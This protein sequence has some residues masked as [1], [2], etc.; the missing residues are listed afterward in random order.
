[1]APIALACLLA[2]SASASSL[3]A[4]SFAIRAKRV[5]PCG[6]RGAQAIENGVVVVRDGR[7]VAVGADVPIPSDL[8]LI[9]LPDGV[10]C[11]GFVDAGTDLVG[12]H[13]GDESVSGVYRAIDGFDRY[14]DYRT[15]LETGVTT[16][17]IDPGSHRLISGRA[18]VVR[19]GGDPAS[20]VLVADGAIT[21]NLGVFGAQPI[22]H[23]PFYASSDEMI[24]PGRAQRPSSRLSALAEAQDQIRR[25]AMGMP[26]KRYDIHE[27]AFAE[28]WRSQ[29]PVRVQAREAVDIEGAMRLLS[30]QQRACCVVGLT[31]A[32]DVANEL[33]A[34]G[35]PIVLSLESSYRW[36]ARDLGPS[37]DAM[38]DGAESAGAV[39]RARAGDSPIALTGRGQ[40]PIA[41]LRMIA[42]LA[43]RGGMP[44]D[45]ALRA[46]TSAPA[47]ILG[48]E[49]RVGAIAPGRDA[50]ILVLSGDPLDINS[51]VLR[52]YIAGK[53]AYEAPRGSGALV[54]RAGHVWTGESMMTDAQVLV[55]NGKI[56]AVGARVPHPR[57]ARIIDAG[58]DAFVTPGFIDGHGHLGFEGDRGAAGPD[59]SPHLL[60]AVAN[61]EFHRVARAGVTTVMQTSYG[62][63]Q[64]GSRISAIKTWGVGYERMVAQEL[65]GMY[66]SMTGQEP[67]QGAS[68]IKQAL[69]AGKKY[70]EEWKKYYD[71]LKKWKEAKAAGKKVEV[72]DEKPKEEKEEKV[73]PIT[74]LWD[75]SV[76]GD[77]LPE[78]VEG[79]MTLELDGT[80]ITGKLSDPMGEAE[81]ELSGT[82]NGTSVR[83][84]VEADTD[85]G[86]PVIN[87]ELDVED[88]MKG[89]AGLGDM[90][91][92]QFEATRVERGKVQITMKRSRSRGKDGKPVPPKINEALEPIRMLLKGEIPALVAAD[93]PAEISA[94]LELL[95]DE[96]KIPVVLLDATEATAVVEDLK[97]RA[98]NVGVVAPTRVER[99]R[100]ERPYAEAVDLAGQGVRVALQSNAEDGAR[101]LPNMALFAVSL[102]MGGDAALRALTIDAARMYRVDDHV[103]RLAPGCDG[104]V[105]I[106]SGHPFDAD[107]RLERVIVGGEEVPE[108]YEEIFE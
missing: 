66:F 75:Y 61:R 9:D 108:H 54:V 96:Y 34:S 77:P 69:E 81:V 67:S 99:M 97:K 3:A 17:S 64:A 59:V 13:Y 60:A 98:E 29:A 94:A 26:Q 107:S 68:R 32:D 102:G 6:D 71:E 76:T 30:G 100:D 18:A 95:V 50:D 38:T 73:D 46:I 56:A 42:A 41:D 25:A 93:T 49:D 33:I 39:G 27:L 65:A 36:P 53:V 101:S 84:E 48:V 86:K 45:L 57:D 43:M 104:D 89:T 92:F 105:L 103:G 90:F 88:H 4:D 16:A 24:Q 12:P 79:P 72:K 74:G 87:A 20:R 85:L 22:V 35:L 91:T 55:E 83:L 28:A 58:P 52:T 23:V 8:L 21:I 14:G 19:L 63:S 15:L 47:K 78:P 5:Y 37:E 51:R 82:L 10:V 44:R 31:E 7:I 40:G 70:E 2:I 80:K 106:F 11:P 62:P 1:M